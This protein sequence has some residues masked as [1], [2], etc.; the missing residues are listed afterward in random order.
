MTVRSLLTTAATE[1]A[2]AV[3]LR[4]TVKKC[5]RTDA[6]PQRILNVHPGIHACHNRLQQDHTKWGPV[7][8]SP[9]RQPPASPRVL[10]VR[11]SRWSAISSTC[12]HGAQAC[13]V[14]NRGGD[15]YHVSSRRTG[16]AAIGEA[17]GVLGVG[18]F[19]L[20][21][22]RHAG[23]PLLNQWTTD[24]AARYLDHACG[25]TV[26]AE[27]SQYPCWWLNVPGSVFP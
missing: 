24:H 4:R 20:S 11:G 13:T 23:S 3:L 10:S 19:E 12:L 16:F 26:R 2:S 27:T 14:T 9:R 7:I 22:Q 6:E 17:V 15:A 8:E 5:L 1:Q 25:T 18:L 21:L